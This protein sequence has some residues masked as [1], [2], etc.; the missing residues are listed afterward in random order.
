MFRHSIA[1]FAWLDVFA[2][3]IVHWTWG[4]ALVL[5]MGDA[6]G[7][8]DRRTRFALAVTTF[9]LAALIVSFDVVFIRPT[10]FGNQA[11]FTLPVLLVGPIVLARTTSKV[12]SR[13]SGRALCLVVCAGHVAALYAV[14]R[15]FGVTVNGPLWFFDR[16]R[17]T[18]PVGWTT[19]AL[20]LAAAS[21]ALL[22]V[23]RTGDVKL[24]DPT[25]R[26]AQSVDEH[27]ST[28]SDK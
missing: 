14:A 2:S 24:T 11:R 12:R 26:L 19:E 6:L 16:S 20:L 27:P 23:P 28:R 8:S 4:A 3:P 1:A 13:A 15:R 10:G 5:I 17:W 21:V 25:P 9:A 22:V 7:M 18:P